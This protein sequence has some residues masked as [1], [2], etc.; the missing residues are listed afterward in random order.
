M[1]LSYAHG[2]DEQ[3]VGGLYES[4]KLAG[5]SLWRN[6]ESMPSCALTFP[7][8]IRVAIDNCERVLLVKL[9]RAFHGAILGSCRAE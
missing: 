2:D 1:I 9:L 7:H 6:K 8:Q 5:M 4:L 3:F